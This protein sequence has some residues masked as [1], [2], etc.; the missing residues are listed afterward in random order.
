M[1]TYLQREIDTNE[2]KV[3][4]IEESESMHIKTPKY[5]YRKVDDGFLADILAILNNKGYITEF[6]CAGHNSDVIYTDGDNYSTGIR[7]DKIHKVSDCHDIYIMFKPWVKLLYLPSDWDY[8]H[9][10]NTIRNSIIASNDI[11][12]YV[13]QLNKLHQLYTW[14]LEMPDYNEIISPA[15]K[16]TRDFLYYVETEEA[17]QKFK[18]QYTLT[19]KNDNRIKKAGRSRRCRMVYSYILDDIILNK[20]FSRCSDY[21]TIKKRYEQFLDF[22]VT[23]RDKTLQF[24]NDKRYKYFSSKEAKVL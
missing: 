17:Y 14:A 13:E 23:N 11:S 6:S 10:I 12:F 1:G 22:Y 15:M 24:Y 2:Y 20:N 16:S 9:N 7:S 8:D 5:I 19:V 21:K 3:I 18:E 4:R